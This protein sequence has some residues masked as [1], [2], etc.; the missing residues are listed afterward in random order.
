VNK[1]RIL[2][3]TA[4][5]RRAAS[6]GETPKLEIFV[7]FT[8]LKQTLATLRSAH[9]L[10]ANLNAKI[11][12]LAAQVVPYPLPLDQPP[13]PVSFI[14]QELSAAAGDLETAINVYLCR[15]RVKTIRQ[16]LRHGSLVLIGGRKH[17]WPTADQRLVRKLTGDG[18]RVLWEHAHNA[19]GRDC[20]HDPAG[21]PR[22]GRLY[23]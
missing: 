15:D 16:V 13:V 6:S 10:A 21:A 18:H 4:I 22:A 17:W 20:F 1:E 11:T 2:T 14:E 9:T 5:P 12:I 23:E 19:A 7:I 3:G 8:T